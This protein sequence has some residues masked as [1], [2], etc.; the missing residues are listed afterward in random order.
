MRKTLQRD[1]E[2]LKKNIVLV[3][4]SG[5]GKTT[6]GKIAAEK[7]NM[8]FVDMDLSL[9]A[10]EEA[11]IDTM[12]KRYGEIG[13]DLQ[14]LSHFKKQILNKDHPLFAASARVLNYKVFW[15]IVEQN[16]IS[17]HLRGKPLDV[18]MR[19]E[20]WLGK[21]KIT[22]EE[23]ADKRLKSE[24]YDYYKWKLGHCKRADHTVR[25]VGNIQVDKEK[26]CEAIE[27]LISTD[28]TKKKDV[29]N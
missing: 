6:L 2:N 25:V 28:D 10:A 29:S 3:G 14:L 7:L 9:E 11:D 20:M 17:I 5:V 1:P 21:R 22:N 27:Q 13:L 24:F 15:G 19:Q 4:V 8:P 23:K 16:A 18:Y 12:L 26:L